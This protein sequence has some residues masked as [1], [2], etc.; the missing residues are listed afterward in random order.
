LAKEDGRG[1]ASATLSQLA[2]EI[3]GY[4]GLVDSA[5]ELQNEMLESCGGKIRFGRSHEPAKPGRNGY[6]VGAGVA[7]VAAGALFALFLLVLLFL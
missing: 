2:A 5:L 1:I 3:E 6:F 4:S 7:G